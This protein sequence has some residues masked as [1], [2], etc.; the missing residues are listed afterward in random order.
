MVAAL[1]ASHVM[2]ENLQIAEDELPQADSVD[3]QSMDTKF[4][5]RLLMQTGIA[6]VFIVIGVSSLQAIFNV[7]IVTPD[8]KR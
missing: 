6:F 8:I 2:F 5:R 7:A 4:L 3:W 1:A